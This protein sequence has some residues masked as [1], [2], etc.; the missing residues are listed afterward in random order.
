MQAPTLSSCKE[1]SARDCLRAMG[2]AASVPVN[3]FR[4]R[5]EATAVED[6][7]AQAAECLVEVP[8]AALAAASAGRVVPEGAG[9]VAVECSV[10]ADA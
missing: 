6:A 9:R 5:P 2:P 4:T 10:G 1:R 8:V 7:E 3:L